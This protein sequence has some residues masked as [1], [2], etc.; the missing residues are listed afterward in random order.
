MLNLLKS[1]YTVRVGPDRLPEIIEDAKERVSKYFG[2]PKYLLDLKY[3]IARLP[4][5]YEV[6]IKRSGNYV[7]R[8]FRR[9]GKVLGIFD[10]FTDEVYIDPINLRNKSYLRRTLIHELVHKAQKVLGKI[11]YYNPY[12]LEREA[13]S[14]ADKLI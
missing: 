6:G 13:Y 4:S 2:I 11:G 7:L 5:I 14:I 8:Y 1:L 10:P 12:L 9:V 3:K